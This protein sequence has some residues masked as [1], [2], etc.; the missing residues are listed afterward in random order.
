MGAAGARGNTAEKRCNRHTGQKRIHRF[1]S[2]IANPNRLGQPDGSQVACQTSST[3][4]QK[5][6]TFSWQGVD[7][8]GLAPPRSR[9]VAA[10]V[11]LASFHRAHQFHSSPVPL[12]PS[13]PPAPGRSAKASSIGPRKGRPVCA[14][15]GER[16]SGGGRPRFCVSRSKLETGAASTHGA[17]PAPATPSPPPRSP[18]PPSGRGRAACT[19]NAPTS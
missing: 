10:V 2:G 4:T 11:N 7:E 19:S 18:S 14:V 6:K 8:S 3:G 17:L 12:C 5:Q 9:Q 13:H 15:R 1:I 16:T